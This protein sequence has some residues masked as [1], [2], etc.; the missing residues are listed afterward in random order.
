MA[1]AVPTSASQ[2]AAGL[3][4][5]CTDRISPDF[6]A[7]LLTVNQD[8]QIEEMR[9]K[10]LLWRDRA[11]MGCAIEI[12][13][14]VACMALFD[15]QRSPLIPVL[16]T[17]LTVLSCFGLNGAVRIRI[18]FIWAHGVVTSGLIVACCLNFLCETLLTDAGLSGGT[19][20]RWFVLVLL[21]VPYS[22]N[23][24]CSQLSLQLGMALSALL[25]VE[26]QAL[27][28]LSSE[29]LEQQA[30]ELRGQSTCCVC[31]TAPNDSVLTPCGHKA[32]CLACAQHL[33]KRSRACPICRSTIGGV[34]RVFES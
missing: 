7:L 22:L 29:K 13:V 31:L 25:E 4:Y 24:A 32:M 2:A 20:P 5:K 33:L 21:L 1:L 8:K 15:I 30:A 27:G 18:S 11:I 19:V 26:E 6:T 28:L 16:N 23:L 3:S 17:L 9:Q 34:V 10:V 12:A 14:S